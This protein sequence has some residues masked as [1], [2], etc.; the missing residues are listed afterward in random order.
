M[1]E[2]INQDHRN[3]L[4][5]AEHLLPATVAAGWPAITSLAMLGPLRTP[6]RSGG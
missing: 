2:G 4:F 1:V 3:P 6:T 5:L